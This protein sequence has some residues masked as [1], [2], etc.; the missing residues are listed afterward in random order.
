MLVADGFDEAILGVLQIKGRPD[1]VCYD[2]ERC[3]EILCDRDKMT[4]AEAQ[5]YMEFNVVD[6]YVGETTPAFLHRGDRAMVEE[7]DL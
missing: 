5:E 2:Y 4:V 6:A 3:V 1:I 7:W